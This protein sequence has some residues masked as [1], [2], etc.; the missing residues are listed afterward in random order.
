MF[1][2]TLLRPSYS[3]PELERHIKP[4]GRHPLGG[5]EFYTREVVKRILAAMDQTE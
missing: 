5:V 4:R 2:V 1:A 3:E